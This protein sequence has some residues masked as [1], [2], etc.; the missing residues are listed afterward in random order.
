MHLLN[1]RLET[2]QECVGISWIR[3]DTF[4]HYSRDKIYVWNFNRFYTTFNLFKCPVTHIQRIEAPG[5]CARILA[6]GL[7]G[8]MRLLSPITGSTISTAFPVI[9][10]TNIVNVEY[11]M[12]KGIMITKEAQIY[13]YI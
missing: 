5:K 4:Y 13:V 7:D 12:I 1:S 8:S 9:R 3:T 6:A 2:A 11:D 10:E